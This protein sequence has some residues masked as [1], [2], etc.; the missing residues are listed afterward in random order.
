MTAVRLG[1]EYAWFG[2]KYADGVGTH[3]HRVHFAAYYIF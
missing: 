1:L 3:D 2:Q